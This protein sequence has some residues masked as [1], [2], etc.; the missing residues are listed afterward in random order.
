MAGSGTIPTYS[1]L[2][3]NIFMTHIKIS[4]KLQGLI[5]RFK[6]VLEER[7]ENPQSYDAS[8]YFQKSWSGSPFANKG[9]VDQHGDG[10]VYGK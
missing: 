3:D 2:A 4:P 1:I 8:K 6:H 5:R 9:W 10:R 7:I